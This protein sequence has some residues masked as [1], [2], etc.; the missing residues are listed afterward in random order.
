MRIKFE[1]DNGLPVNEILNIP[2]CVI[3]AR[4]VF[5]E[6]GKFYP[7]VY[8]KHCYLE[9]EHADDSF[10]CCRTLLKSLSNSEYGRFLSKNVTN[11]F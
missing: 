8:L 10:V 7:Q 6:N 3:I 9:Y 11:L 4:S 5:E 1:S 2:A